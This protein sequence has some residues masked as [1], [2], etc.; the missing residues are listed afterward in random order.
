MRLLAYVESWQK[1]C[2]KCTKVHVATVDDGQDV[3]D[4]EIR[5][6]ANRYNMTDERFDNVENY[7]TRRSGGV[8]FATTNAQDFR[9]GYLSL[10]VAFCNHNYNEAKII[11]TLN[12]FLKQVLPSLE[13]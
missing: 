7:L 12:N 8:L 10:K 3:Y 4:I 6:P 13:K 11:E 2:A 5:F 9:K 1:E